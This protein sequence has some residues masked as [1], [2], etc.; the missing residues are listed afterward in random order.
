MN[1]LLQ[2]V[3]R[4]IL[5]HALLP[6]GSRVL[7]G[8][9]G[10]SDSVGLLRA[11]LELQRTSDFTVAGAAHFNHRLRDTAARDEAF[12]RNLAHDLGI[13]FTTEAADVAAYAGAERLSIEDAA[14]RLRYDFLERAARG[15][16]ATHV[17][18]GHTL[19]DQAETVLL[20]L[21][22]GAGPSGLGGV[23][24]EKGIV[25]RP[26]LDVSRDDVRAWLAA[27]GQSWVEDETNADVS[28][29]RNRVRHRVLPELDA[30]YGGSTR[31]A[32]ARSAELARDD[33]QWLDE[34]AAG[35]YS[36]LVKVGQDCLQVDAAALLAE[37]AA[38]QRRVLLL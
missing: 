3:R 38:M 26:L 30:A 1:A 25:I 19:D 35:R 36:D 22:R 29:P 17:A 28:N 37:P 34:L 27:I 8:V 20:K 13:P 23:Y 24:P 7:V 10:G 16:G 31:G 33:G 11:L 9:S 5:R 2:Q 15:A 18:V 4:S 32:I 14:R 12:C 21:M 6:S